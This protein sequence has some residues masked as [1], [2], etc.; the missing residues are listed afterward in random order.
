MALAPAIAGA[1]TA[2]FGDPNL[3]KVAVYRE[4]GLEPGRP[5]RAALR[6]PDAILS[7]FETRVR[8]QQATILVRVSEVA[9]PRVHD[10]ITI[11]GVT[12]VVK[13]SVRDLSGG[14]WRIEVQAR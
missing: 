11:E 3:T 13:S 4:G 5:I 9:N 8:A 2:I 14:M 12:Y 1:F 6:S 10:D 7:P